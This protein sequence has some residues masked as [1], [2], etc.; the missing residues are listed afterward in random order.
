MASGEQRSLRHFYFRDQGQRQDFVSPRSGG[1]E[2]NIPLRNREEHAQQIKRTLTQALQDAERQIEARDADIEGGT[3][4]FYLEFE[5]PIGQR[6]VLDKLEDRR[7]NAH[8][9]LVS[10]RPSEANPKRD[11]AATVFVPESKKNSYLKKIEKYRTEDT[12]KGRPKNE[13]LVASIDAVRLASGARS[14][15]TDDP[16]SFPADHDN[17]W[18]EVWLRD[19]GRS[20][21]ERAARPLELVVRDHIVEFAER[22]VALV[23]ATPVALGRMIAN[24]DAIAELRLAL[25]TPGIFMQMPA[26]EQ[27]EWAGDLVDRIEQPGEDAPAV[28]VLDSGSTRLHPL[29]TPALHSDDQKAWNATWTIEDIGQWRGHGTQMSG[30][31]LYGDLTSHLVGNDQ[32]TLTHKLETV[33]ILPDW[34]QNDPDLYGYITASAVGVAEVQAPLRKRAFCL[35]VTSAT[36]DWRGRPSSWSAK[37]DDLAF[38]DGTDQRLIVVATG[39][40]DGAYPAHEYLDQN[41]SASV[42]NPAQSWNALTVGAMT[43]KCTIIDQTYA[44]WGVLASSGDLS[45][46]SRTSVSWHDDWPLKPDIVMEGGNYGV[47]PTTNAGDRVDDL[48]LLTTHNRLNERLFTVSGDT[49]A[50]TALVSRMAAQIY[51]DNDTLWPETVRGLIVHSADWTPAMRGHLPVNPLGVH[52]RLLLRRYGYGA[53]DLGRAQRSLNSDVTL[54]LEGELQP[55]VLD[56]GSVKTRDMVMHDLPWP[57]GALEQLGGAD[58]EMRVTLSYFVE[59]NPGERGWTKRHRYSSHGLRFDV[60]RAEESTDQFMR[61]VNKAAREQKD[62]GRGAGAG[63]NDGWVIG[64]RLRDRGSLHS[65]IWQ[66]SAADLAGRHGIA[67]YPVGGWWR[68]KKDL[69]RTDRSVRYALIVTVRA[70]ADIDLYAEIQAAVPV[71]A[72]VEI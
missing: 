13:A 16:E 57:R 23:R 71:E 9:E 49:S 30:L 51:A 56:D 65:D 25:D 10:V 22:E 47:D 64:P 7:G 72:E 27:V 50:A 32:I 60:K 58:V 66:G 28:C 29:I 40:I 26:R 52:K 17:T 53:P 4:G 38:G 36:P 42:E 2:D 31:V 55:F 70:A 67:V 11:I 12:P 6:A 63:G 37:L 15:F 24:S 20:V 14:L 62:D 39:N 46:Y 8:I 21:L 3:R 54:V 34:G 19:D 45:P 59:P 43:D 18:W 35:A 61:R 68:E 5:L 44:G 41:D 1:G 69:E 48:C 33:K